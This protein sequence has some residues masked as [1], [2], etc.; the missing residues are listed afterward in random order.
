MPDSKRQ[1]SPAKGRNLLD[2]ELGVEKIQLRIPPTALRR[3]LPNAT[4]YPLEIRLV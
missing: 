3:S 4:K 2:E 1:V